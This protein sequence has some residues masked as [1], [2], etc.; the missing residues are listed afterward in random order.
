MQSKQVD[1]STNC[2]NWSMDD[3]DDSRDTQNDNSRQQ[4]VYKIALG[5]GKR[6]WTREATLNYLDLTRSPS[7]RIWS[8]NTQPQ[9][10]QYNEDRYVYDTQYC[11]TYWVSFPYSSHWNC[12]CQMRTLLVL[13]PT[14]PANISSIK[15][16]SSTA[17]NRMVLR[18]K[19]TH[20][21]K[22]IIRVSLCWWV[23]LI[24]NPDSVT[25]VHLV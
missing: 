4:Y 9:K 10:Y 14:T 16:I 15:P 13:L 5:L 1:I 8:G 3:S 21:K 22:Y 17:N 2:S 6:L 23:V 11:K 20:L 12:Y 25:I 24:P 18:F 19:Q 7:F